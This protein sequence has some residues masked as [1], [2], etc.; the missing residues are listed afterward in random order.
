MI[1]DPDDIMM[2][3]ALSA[4]QFFRA[5]RFRIPLKPAFPLGT[6]KD[7]TGRARTQA[8]QEKNSRKKTA[9]LDHYTPA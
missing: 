6:D 9:P 7:K 2:M 3:A 4:R 5:L 8:K 1:Q